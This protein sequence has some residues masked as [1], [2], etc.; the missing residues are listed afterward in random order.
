MAFTAGTAGTTATT[1]FVATTNTGS[2]NTGSSSPITISS[3]T[4]DS[5][6]T[7]RVYAI[8]AHGTSAASDASSSV[9]P[10]ALAGNVIYFAGGGDDVIEFRNVASTGNSSDFGDLTST[11]EGGNGTASSTRGFSKKEKLTQVKLEK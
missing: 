2:G 3:L 6:V 4:N 8:N 7:V 9:T 1:G 11:S 10:S 5:A